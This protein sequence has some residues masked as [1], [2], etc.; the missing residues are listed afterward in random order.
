MEERSCFSK[1]DFLFFDKIKTKKE[2]APS[3]SMNNLL[4]DTPSLLLSFTKWYKN[5]ASL[6]NSTK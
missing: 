4:N 6:E 3:E 2:R 1:L 5:L